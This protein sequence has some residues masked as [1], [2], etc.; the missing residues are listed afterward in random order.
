M[1]IVLYSNTRVSMINNMMAR[2]VTGSLTCENNENEG[3]YE[4]IL[5]LAL[6]VKKI[7]LSDISI[8]SLYHRY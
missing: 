6:G 3:V 4:N 1:G 5:V 8:L 7:R 2:N